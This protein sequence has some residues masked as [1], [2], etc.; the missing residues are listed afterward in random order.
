[1]KILSGPW[2]LQE[3]LVALTSLTW[4][5]N[6]AASVHGP[7]SIL[8]WAVSYIGCAQPGLLHG[9]WTCVTVSPTTSLASSCPHWL[10]GLPRSTLV[11]S[12]IIPPCLQSCDSSWLHPSPCSSPRLIWDCQWITRLSPPQP[13]P[14]P[15]GQCPGPVCAVDAPGSLPLIA[16]NEWMVLHVQEA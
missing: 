11:W 15:V 7:R 2:G 13:C 3:S 9:S 8:V 1:M 12:G 6:Q 14:D 5:P 10:P 16:N 4:V